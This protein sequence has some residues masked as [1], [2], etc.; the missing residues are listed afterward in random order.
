MN[1]PYRTPAPAPLT[2]EQEYAALSSELE[3]L[4]CINAAGVPH[5]EL[6]RRQRRVQVVS[7]RLA[8]MQR[9]WDREAWW[10]ALTDDQRS[11]LMALC[12]R[13]CGALD[14]RCPCCRD[15]ERD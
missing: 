1:G 15:T 13:G 5:E 2:P 11:E 14:P 9:A 8:T 10:R 4:R 3:M 6:A 12:C 7:A